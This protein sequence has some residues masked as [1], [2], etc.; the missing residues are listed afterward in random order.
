MSSSP[1]S[2]LN[3]RAYPQGA[4]LDASAASRPKVSLIVSTRGRTAE[5]DKFLSH[6]DAQTYTNF[7]IVIVDQNEDNRIDALLTRHSLRQTHLRSSERG[8]S[9]GRNAG[10]VKAQGDILAIPDDDCWYT[11]KVLEEVTTFF[12]SRPEVDV[13]SVVECNPDGEPM[14]PKRP[15]AA[16]WCDTRPVGLVQR[17]S[18]WVPQSSMIFLRRSVYEKVGFFSAW[19][20]VGGG[21]QFES[22]EET[23]YL[24]RAL[25]AGFRMWFEPSIRVFH[26][27]LRTPE[28]LANS[29]YRYAV[30]GGGLMRRHG[31]SIFNLAALLCRCLGGAAWSALR[32]DVNSATM[33]LRRAKGLAIGYFS[34]PAEHKLTA[35]A[36]IPSPWYRPES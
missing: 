24:L 28:R 3:A 25:R 8:L 20:G 17:R 12:E 19:M 22:G 7:E 5:L 6:L 27:E 15:P 32:R 34:L 11:P 18:A 4:N 29:N 13:L 14:I 21:T 36:Q 23:D 1:S 9:R 2:E 31:C 10:L 26:I 33:Y 35:E 16:G 30:G